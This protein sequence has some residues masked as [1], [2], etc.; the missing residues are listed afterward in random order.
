MDSSSRTNGRGERALVCKDLITTEVTCSVLGRNS[1]EQPSKG[2]HLGKPTSEPLGSSDSWGTSTESR[3]RRCVDTLALEK[4]APA[5]CPVYV[6]RWRN[7]SVVLGSLHVLTRDF[8]IFVIESEVL[9]VR[10]RSAAAF[11][12]ASFRGRGGAHCLLR[13]TS[14]T[15]ARG[16]RGGALG[17]SLGGAC[18]RSR[19]SDCRAPQL[20]LRG[21]WGALGLWC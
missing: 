18:S 15:R 8:P 10:R 19:Q 11:V 17:H 21:L 12:L 13:S 1:T 16:E 4:L 2:L 6:P 7:I 5:C 20:W 3:L 9:S 14:G